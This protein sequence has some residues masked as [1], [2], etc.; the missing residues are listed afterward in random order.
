MNRFVIVDGLPYLL[1]H[2]KTYAVRWDDKGF[3][4]GMEVELASIPSVTHGELAIK[5]KC[6]RHGI[7]VIDLAE[8][9][10]FSALTP[11]YYY[12]ETDNLHPSALGH[13]RIANMVQAELEKQFR[14]TTK[15]PEDEPDT[16]VTY[17]PAIGGGIQVGDG[18]QLIVNNLCRTDYIALDGYAR[19]TATYRLTS[20]AY[21]LAFYDSNKTLLP[22]AS[23]IGAGLDSDNNVDMGIP[24]GAAYCIFSH[25]AGNSNQ[26]AGSITL[27]KV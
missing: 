25:Y 19:I 24:A 5:A 15:N 21:A 18:S 10:G 22:N 2:G 8:H 26:W 11:E 1:A 20:N 7:P 27:H 17:V 6:A 13:V 4:V 16:S 9:S 3:T 14:N 12:S 23:V